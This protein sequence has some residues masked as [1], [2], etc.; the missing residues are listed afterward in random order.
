MSAHMKKL[1]TDSIQIEI[2]NTKKRIFSVPKDKAKGVLSLLR[3]YEVE[4]AV[5]WREVFKKDLEQLSEPALALKGARA[6]VGLTQEQLAS[7]LKTSQPSVAQMEQGK[8]AI[9]TAMA[10]KLGQIFNIGY[11]VFL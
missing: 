5:E 7:L 4:Q 9:T 10:K 2:G 3:E 1:P 11:K 8:R 6:K